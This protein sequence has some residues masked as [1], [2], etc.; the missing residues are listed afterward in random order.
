MEELKKSINDVQLV[1]YFGK[2]MSFLLPVTS[3]SQF[4]VLFSQLDQHVNNPDDNIGIEGYG[5]SMTTLEEVC[6]V[7][8]HTFRAI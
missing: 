5:I 6:I 1:R 7:L 2:E 3:A 4:T 8:L